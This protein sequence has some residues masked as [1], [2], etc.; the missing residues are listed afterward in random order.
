MKM[1]VQLKRMRR[2]LKK[3][4]WDTERLKKS[5]CE[6]GRLVDETVSMN[7]EGTVEKSWNEIK[8]KITKA[9]EKVIGYKKGIEARKPWVS[10]S[11][12]TKMEERR[13]WKAVNTGE[14]R[15]KYRLFKQ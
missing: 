9:A 8:D 7:E 4:K 12:L 10:A 3:R 2:G 1:R 13:K 6:F 14:R 5:G 11:M 15:M